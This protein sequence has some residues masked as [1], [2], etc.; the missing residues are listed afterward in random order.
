MQV[1]KESLPDDPDS[2]GLLG[3]EIFLPYEDKT[4]IIPCLVKKWFTHLCVRSLRNLGLDW[5]PPWIYDSSVKNKN[6]ESQF[7]ITKIRH[8][9]CGTAFMMHICLE[10]GIDIRS[11]HLQIF[12]IF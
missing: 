7:G 4:Y 11:A 12:R 2:D 1:Q 6:L 9:S 8:K 5:S 3:H 10:S